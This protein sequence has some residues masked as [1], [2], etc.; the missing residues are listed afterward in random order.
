MPVQE[1]RDD[2]GRRDS[3]GQPFPQSPKLKSETALSP[4]ERLMKAGIIPTEEAAG[5][6]TSLKLPK[7]DIDVDVLRAKKS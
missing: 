3:N 7:V 5:I 2:Q 4:E 1:D 6:D